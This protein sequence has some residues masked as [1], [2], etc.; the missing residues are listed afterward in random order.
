[1]PRPRP[2]PR[3]G[4]PGGRD[5]RRRAARAGRCPR[6]VLEG[7]SG[8][9]AAACSRTTR[10]WRMASLH[11]MRRPSTS[12]GSDLA[13]SLMDRVLARFADPAGGF[14]DTADDHE[15]LVTRP[16]DV[17]D[18]AVPSGNAMAARVLLRLAAW[19]G[20]GE[21]RDAGG[22]RAALGGA[23]RRP[24][25]DRVRPVAVGD[26]P[27]ARAGSSRSRSSARP[28]TRRRPPSSRRSGAAHRRT[29]SSRVA[30]DPAA[31]AVR[32]WPTGSRS[33]GARRRTSA[34]ASSAGCRSP[35][36]RRSAPSSTPPDGRWLSRLADRPAGRRPARS[37]CGPRTQ[38]DGRPGGGP[39]GGD[40]RP[41]PAGVGRARG[42]AHPPPDDDGLRGRRPRLPGRPGR[43]R[44]CR[45]GA[46]RR[47]RSCP[48]AAAAAALGG[49]LAPTVA[50]AAYLA[51]IRE[52]FEEAG[53]LLAETTASPARRRG[54]AVGP[55][56][57]RDRRSR[58]SPTRSTC[59]C[60]RI[61][62]SRCRAG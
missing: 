42:A 17:Q 14:F 26:G 51:A 38:G 41:A 4:E 28:T 8:G 43:P 25:S 48:A 10:I 49:D 55:A 23:V 54:G 18:N 3:R 11:C 53:V 60:G 50:L 6:P 56:P 12:D 31:S 46:C 15:R 30:A 20:E 7:R 19:T 5:D 61:C 44:R 39:A 58:T 32:C 13:R 52:L 45:P 47:G 35:I 57:R 1:M 21:Y 2:L 33:T 36:R 62:S 16:K 24:L 37:R 29:R 59:G 34:A 22:A 27:G 9:R 40:R